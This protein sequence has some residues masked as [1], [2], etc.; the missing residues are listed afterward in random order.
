M[1]PEE[2][3]TG[4]ALVAGAPRVVGRPFQSGQSGNPLGR[5][6]G[7]TKSVQRKVGKRGEKLVEALWLL[8]YGTPAQRKEFFGE[9]VKVNTK[10]R[11]TALSELADR[12]FGRPA[13]AVDLTGA[14]SI[15]LQ[16]VTGVPDVRGPQS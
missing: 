12:G 5:P 6:S 10:D 3:D 13:Q 4:E 14:P 15:A 11:L 9:P 8:A 7:L 16:V 2:N 1:N